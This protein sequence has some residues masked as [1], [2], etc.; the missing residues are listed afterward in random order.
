LA[1]CSKYVVKPLIGH[2]ACCK[3]MAL[4]MQPCSVVVSRSWREMPKQLKSQVRNALDAA[5]IQIH[6]IERLPLTM[7]NVFV[8]NVLDLEHKAGMA[9]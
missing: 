4:K 8:H 2:K 6:S 9:A 5:K 3:V 1:S 7:E